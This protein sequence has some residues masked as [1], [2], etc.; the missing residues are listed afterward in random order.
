MFHPSTNGLGRFSLS[1]QELYA[2]YLGGKTAVVTPNFRALPIT[3]Q[4]EPET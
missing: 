4:L 2:P 1:G 3:D